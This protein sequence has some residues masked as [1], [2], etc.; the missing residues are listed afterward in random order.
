MGRASL[1]QLADELLPVLKALCHLRR[2][3]IWCLV[4]HF[5]R[6]GE[7]VDLPIVIAKELL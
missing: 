4:P 2:A 1:E 7:D 6:T 3:T 5:D